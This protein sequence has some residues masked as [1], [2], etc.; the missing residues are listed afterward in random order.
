MKE[1]KYRMVMML[2]LSLGIILFIIAIIAL[3][4]NVEEIK[5]DPIIYGIDKKG[6]DYCICYTEDGYYTFVEGEKGAIKNR[7]F[8]RSAFDLSNILE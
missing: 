3:A 1:E 5:T 6:F 7:P 8:E 4:K 2:L